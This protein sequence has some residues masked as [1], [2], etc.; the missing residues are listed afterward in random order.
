MSGSNYLL[1]NH[2]ANS[3]VSDVHIK[4]SQPGL[5]SSQLVPSPDLLPLLE[6]VAINKNV[7]ISVFDYAFLPQF[8]SFYYSSLLP[9]HITNF[10]A[11]A[12]DDRTYRVLFSLHY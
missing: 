1:S 9:L 11:F 6:K 8:Y 7:I 3:G 10:I 5:R 2:K 4:V 12:M